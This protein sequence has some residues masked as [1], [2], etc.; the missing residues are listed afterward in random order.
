[1]IYEYLKSKLNYDKPE[2]CLQTLDE[3]EKD[4]KRLRRELGGAWTYCCGCKSY[5]RLDEAVEGWTDTGRPVKRCGSCAS[6]W[7]FLD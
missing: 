4:L 3:C 7:K 5:V 1:M 2:E 6:I